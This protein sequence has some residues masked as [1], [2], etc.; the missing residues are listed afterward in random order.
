MADADS[1][2]ET[3]TRIRVE[4]SNTAIDPE[5][6]RSDIEHPD[7]GAHAWF[8][9]V[10]RRTTGDRIT[11]SLFYEAHASMAVKQLQR[12]AADAAGRFGLVAV[13]MVHRLGHVP[14]GDCAILLGVSSPHRVACFESLAWLMDR[15]KT[16]VPVWK[17]ETAGGARSGAGQGGAKWIHP[18]YDGESTR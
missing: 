1:D 13:V 10:T 3:K 4:L 11:E 6:F 2:A 18:G 16:E 9:G 15:I 7:V 17:R 14:V 5:S 8:A 12:L